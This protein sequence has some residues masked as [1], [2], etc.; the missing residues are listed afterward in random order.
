MSDRLG[1]HTIYQSLGGD[2]NDHIA[3]HATTL[4]VV[5]GD[6]LLLA[7]DG[8]TDVVAPPV[9]TDMLGHEGRDAVTRLLKMAEDAG[10]P[11][12]VTIVTVDICAD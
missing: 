11:D 8:L 6:R 10:T 2:D 3:P 4:E 12:D 9:V 5:V 7:T 1:G